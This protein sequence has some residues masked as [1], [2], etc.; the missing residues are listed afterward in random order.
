MQRDA[1]PLWLF[2][3]AFEYRCCIEQILRIY[4]ELTGIEWSKKLLKLY[5]GSDLKK[6]ILR[7][8]PEFFDKLKFVDVLIRA[9]GHK[10]VYRLDLD[11]LSNQH[12]RLGG[13][14]H[15]QVKPYETVCSDPWWQDFWDMLEEVRRDLS[16][17]VSHD[18]AYPQLKGDWDLYNAWKAGSKTEK[19][20][21]EELKKRL[22]RSTGSKSVH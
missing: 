15:A 11:Q 13:Y 2:Y 16:N 21:G 8:E 3:I 19:E 6:E 22:T 20:I 14:L 17:V 9:L 10:G 1:E 18:L 7:R 12:G 5:A 4:L